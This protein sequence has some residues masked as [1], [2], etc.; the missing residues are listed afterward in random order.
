MNYVTP[1]VT[2]AALSSVKQGRMIDLSHELKIGA[3]QIPPFMPPYLLGMWANPDTTRR[4]V[5]EKFDAKNDL[6]VFTERVSL[7]M[8]TGTHVDALGHL[9]IGDEMFNG[10]RY[11][12]SSSNFGLERLGIEQ[13]PPMITRGVCLDVGGG[14]DFLEGGRVVTRKHL[15]NALDKARVELRPGDAVLLRTGWGRF[16]MTDNARYAASQPGIDEDAAR[17]LAERKICAIGADNMTVEVM[18]NPDPRLVLPVHQ[19][20][21]VE[22]GVYLIENL[23]LDHV[24]REGLTTFCLIMLPVKF[25]GATGCPVRPVALL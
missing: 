8:H 11:Q 2:L 3:P 16:Y 7:C 6:G 23:V 5:K 25:T 10:W 4:L 9:T 13:M 20:T 12:T 17:W 24:V 14:G 19:Y 15:E 18:P 22:A 1:E 21:L